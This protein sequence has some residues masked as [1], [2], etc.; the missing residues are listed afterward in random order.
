[1][2]ILDTETDDECMIFLLLLHFHLK[3]YFW[4]FKFGST[5]GLCFFPMFPC[6]VSLTCRCLE[7]VYQCLRQCA[8][9]HER[10]KFFDTFFSLSVWRTVERN[11][12]YL[13]L[14]FGFHE[15][16]YNEQDDARWAFYYKSNLTL[17]TPFLSATVFWTIFTP[18]LWHRLL[19]LA[20]CVERHGPPENAGEQR[21]CVQP[22]PSR[23]S[24]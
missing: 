23:A 4:W 18:L 16:D 6:G 20:I 9:K 1:M 21:M 14:Q 22:R 8:L 12:L 11:A 13:C 24:R 2:T 10:C 5:K 7:P 15:D 19:R 3:D 17:F